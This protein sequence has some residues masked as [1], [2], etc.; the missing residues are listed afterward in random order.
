MGNWILKNILNS[1][2]VA[3]YQVPGPEF[4]SS[5]KKSGIPI[6]FTWLQASGNR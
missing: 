1:L 2:P 5:F 4:A 6:W 3:G